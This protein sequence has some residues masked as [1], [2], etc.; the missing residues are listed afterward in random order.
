MAAIK[1]NNNNNEI[2]KK[3]IFEFNDKQR[4]SK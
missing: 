3:L 2:K 1:I 4:T